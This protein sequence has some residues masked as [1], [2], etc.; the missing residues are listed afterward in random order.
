MT[1]LELMIDLH[2]H[3]NRQGPGSDSDTLKALNLTR[4]SSDKK[5]KVADI[6]CGTGGQ[7][8]TLAKNIEGEIK[9]LDLFPGFLED[10]Q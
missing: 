9:A 10:T 3:S 4:L 5:I 6:G 1:E 8:L 2:K 7:T